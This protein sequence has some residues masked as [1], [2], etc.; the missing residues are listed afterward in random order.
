MLVVLFQKCRYPCIWQSVV[1][2][3][4]GNAETLGYVCSRKSW[5]IVERDVKVRKSRV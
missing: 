2:G 3:Y 5:F 4:P 1:C